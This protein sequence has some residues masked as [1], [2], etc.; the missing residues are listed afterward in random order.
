[1]GAVAVS[2]IMQIAVPVPNPERARAFY[3][4]VLGLTHLFDAPPFLSFFGAA[5]PG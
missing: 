2:K 1:M 5:R 3:S 4:D